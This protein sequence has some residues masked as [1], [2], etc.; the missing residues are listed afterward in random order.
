MGLGQAMIVAGVGCRK[1]AAAQEIDAAIA[2]ALANGKFA[3]DAL[4]VIA[5]AAGKGLEQGIMKAA[6]ARGVP[7]VLVTDKDLEAA[8]GRAVTK[9]KRVQKL[10]GVPSVSE[11]A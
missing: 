7:L 11:C 9:S 3:S 2:E 1:G 6:A 5:T 8:S 4:T 10:M